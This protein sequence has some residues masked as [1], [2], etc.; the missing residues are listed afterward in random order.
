VPEL[1][2]TGVDPGIS[3]GLAGMALIAGV[4]LLLTTRRRE[5]EHAN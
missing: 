5:A 4:A 3:L 1:A 2:D